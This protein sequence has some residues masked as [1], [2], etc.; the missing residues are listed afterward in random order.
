MLATLNG[1]SDNQ[2]WYCG[3]YPSMNHYVPSMKFVDASV[4]Q[5]L[6]QVE[7]ATTATPTSGSIDKLLKSFT[8]LRE[9][10]SK[11]IQA[12]RDEQKAQEDRHSKDMQAST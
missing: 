7:Q 2:T 6:Q 4:P 5:L 12:L 11:G 10:Y 3:N 1:C 9:E 8:S